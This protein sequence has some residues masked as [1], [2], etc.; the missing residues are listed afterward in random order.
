M[1]KKKRYGRLEIKV[2]T[3]FCDDFKRLFDLTIKA[4]ENIFLA[5]AKKLTI[6]QKRKKKKRIPRDEALYNLI[7]KNHFFVYFN[8]MPLAIHWASGDK[9]LWKGNGRPPKRLSDMLVCLHIWQKFPSLDCRDAHAFLEFLKYYRII[10]VEIP[11][12]KTLCN[13]K[14]NPCVKTYLDELIKIT[15]KPLSKIEKDFATDMTGTKT[16][17]FTSWYSIRTGETIQKRDHIATH[18]TTGVKSNIVTAVNINVK[19]GGDN[20]I[21]RRHVDITDENFNINDWSADSKYWCKKNCRKLKEKGGNGWF[22]P[23]ENFS[24][25]YVKCGLF[26]RMSR[27]LLNKEENAL[28]S[29][30]KRSNVESTI[31]SKKSKL[32][33]FVR[34][35]LEIGQEQE[36]YI[37]WVNYNFAVLGRA[38]FEWG[39]EPDF[40][41]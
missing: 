34:S 35:R 4:E 14:N 13:Y 16:K 6:T 21:L 10:D 29:Y 33:D 28:K 9:T 32:G 30:H 17:T 18:I 38:L 19:S 36:E 11:C 37:K 26:N 39:I 8:Y 20:E 24:G 23:H 1:T 31:H 2:L 40:S 25:R 27:A 12:F 15:S 3:Y 41:L 5:Y 7:R 22:W